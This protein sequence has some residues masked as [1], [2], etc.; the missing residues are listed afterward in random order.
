MKMIM[1]GRYLVENF[2]GTSMG[3]P[4]QGM[5]LTGYDNI[6]KKY[7]SVWVDNFGTGIMM[8]EGDANDMGGLTMYGK[9]N[10]PMGGV[11]HMKGVTSQHDKNTVNF[12]MFTKTPDGGWD[13]MME[14]IYNRA[15]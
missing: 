6:D 3:M 11:M 2:E 15:G 7:K 5:G 12:E 8:M 13:K 4:F 1:G 10:D 14:I 9:M